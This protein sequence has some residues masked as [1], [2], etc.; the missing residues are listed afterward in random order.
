MKNCLLIIIAFIS[1][2][3]SSCDND[4]ITDFEG[5]YISNKEVK[6]GETTTFS[7]M[8]GEDHNV[9]LTVTFYVDD[10]KVGEV[11]KIPYKFDY[12]IPKQMELGIHKVS[13]DYTGKK[14]GAT[15][16]G[17]ISLFNAFK[18]IE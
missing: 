9:P 10:N 18:V 12:T 6:V 15:V 5:I 3:F 1:V 14:S 8:L 7:L 17:T 16:S 2:I 11:K 4:I 13:A